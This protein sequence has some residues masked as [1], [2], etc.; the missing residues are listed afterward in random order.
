VD[1][2]VLDGIE[3]ISEETLKL[4]KKINVVVAETGENIN[5]A[6]PKIY[7]NMRLFEI[8]KSSNID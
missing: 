6:L 7:L 5:K 1:T 3:Q 2:F 4:V 8:V